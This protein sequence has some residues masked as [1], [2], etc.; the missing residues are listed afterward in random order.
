MIHAN[1]R[2][3]YDVI[4]TSNVA[5]STTAF[6]EF[7]LSII[8]ASLIDAIKPS[9]AMSDGQTDKANLR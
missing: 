1:Q 9:N 5:G 2:A 3:Y 6:I 4:N 7:M 8:K